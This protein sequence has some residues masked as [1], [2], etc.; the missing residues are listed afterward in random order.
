[1]SALEQEHRI[2]GPPGTGK[3]TYLASTV[4]ATAK[5]RHT[6]QIIVGSFTRAAAHEIAGRNLPIPRSQIG[7]LHALAYRALGKPRL[8]VEVIED[9]NRL[10]PAFHLKPRSTDGA[11]TPMEDMRIGD[12]RLAAANDGDV[13]MRQME[14]YRHRM[15]PVEQWDVM[16]RNFHAK[17]EEFKVNQEVVDFTDLIER[18]FEHE[19]A[20]GSPVVGFFDEAQDFTELEMRLIRHW[21]KRMDAL[22]LAADDDQMLYA[23]KGASPTSLLSPIPEDHK[24]ILTQSYRLPRLIHAAAQHW[25]ETLTE[26]ESKHFEPR[27]EDGVVREAAC[28]YRYP[29]TVANEAITI[30]ESGRS[31]MIL[32]ATNAMLTGICMQLKSVGYPFHNPYRPTAWE[33][34]PLGGKERSISPTERLAAYLVCD[35]REFGDDAHLWTGQDLKRW[36]AAV[37]RDRVFRRITGTGSAIAKLPNDRELTFEEIAAVLRPMV[38]EEATEPSLDWFMRHLQ[39]RYRQGMIYPA[40]VVRRQGA[41]ALVTPPKI[42]V[43]TIHSI[44]GAE[45]DVVMLLPDMSPAMWN[46][47][48]QRGPGRD[49]VIRQFYVAMTRAREELV[50]CQI[51]KRLG[52]EPSLLTRGAKLAAKSSSSSKSPG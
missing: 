36:S 46:E 26:R 12:S 30:A 11:R 5:H 28:Y 25:I 9:W 35:E 47:W 31:V 1:M 13:L 6:S 8:A 19:E 52:V 16:T 51:S 21:G 15:V 32:G 17:W 50:V 41:T 37:Q 2:F 24:R 34:N 48:D 22:V 7:T 33:W 43:G 27:D 38:L 49:A 20:P 4:T 23:F 39:N 3:T 40:Q 18:A 42:V 44:K 29:E 10:H 45:A 14:R